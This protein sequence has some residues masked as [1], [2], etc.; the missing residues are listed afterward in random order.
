MKTAIYGAGSLGTVLGAYLA[1]AGVD[2]DLITRNREH[3]EALNRDGAKIIGTVNM[4][5]PVHALTPD[6]MTEK[7]ELII[8]LTKQLDN[9]NVLKNLQKNMTDDCIV[10]T[11]QN[12]LPELSVSEVVGED[13]TMGCTVAWGATLHGKGVSELTSKP[14][15]MSFGLGRMNGQ[16][17]ADIIRLRNLYYTGTHPAKHILNAGS[18]C[19]GA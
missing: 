19:R 4:T 9:V 5:V 7:Y 11:L 12:G 10:C 14:D 15:S 2:V 1:K 3:V 17:A 6:E 18:P 8:L 13:R 16:K